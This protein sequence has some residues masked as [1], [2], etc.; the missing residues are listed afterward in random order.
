MRVLVVVLLATLAKEC[1]AQ[2]ATF[3]VHG[4][5]RADCANGLKLDISDL[6]ASPATT[7]AVFP[8]PG[9]SCTLQLTNIIYNPSSPSEAIGFDWTVTGAC[10]VEDVEVKAG[11]GFRLYRSPTPLG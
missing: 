1:E 7:S 6:P 5:N 3:E 11:P 10:P 2:A 4:G 9:E 8:W